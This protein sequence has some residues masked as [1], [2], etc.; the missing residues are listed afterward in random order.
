MSLFGGMLLY[1]R[2]LAAPGLAGAGSAPDVGWF[3]YAPLTSRAF[4]R[5]HS[6]DY[7]ILGLLI[8]GIG[9]MVSALNV[10]ATIISLRCKGMTFM[11]MPL[12]VW[13]MLVVAGMILL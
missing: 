3:A 7:W 12:F 8:S 10:I 6:T 4:S 1:F 2:Y 13:M 9:S 11:R 5:G